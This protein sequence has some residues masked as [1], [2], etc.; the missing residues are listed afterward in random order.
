MLDSDDAIAVVGVAARVPGARDVEEFWLNLVRGRESVT[1]RTDEELRA[2]GVAEELIADPAYVKTASMMP[3]AEYFDAQLFRMTP[4]EA[5]LCDPQIRLFLEMAH[6]AIEN[7]GYDPGTLR[8]GVGVFASAGPAHYAEQH[9]LRHPEIANSALSGIVTLNHGDYVATTTSYKLDLRGPSVTVLTACSS[10][11]VALHLACQSLRIGDCDVAVVGGADIE[12]PYGHGYLWAPG[13]VRSRDGHCRPFDSAA[14][15]TVFG[16]GACAV[17]VKR[18]DDAIEAG[19]QVRAVI[20]GIALNND[21]ADKVSFGAPSKAGQ[22]A[23]IMEAMALAGVRPEDISYVE[24]HGTGTALGD[25]IEVAAL[26]EAYTRLAG[27]PLPPGRCALGSVKGNVGHLGPVAGIAGLVKAVLALEREQL[28][29][30]INFT[31]PNPRLKIEETP[32]R[33]QDALTAWPRDPERPRR[34]GVSSMGI[35]GSNVHVVLEEPPA[36]RFEPH[37]ERRRVIVW[38]GLTADAEQ[39]ARAP[40]AHYFTARGEALFAD[41]VA[42]LQHGRARHPV[43]AA[44]VCTS[45]HDAATVLRE[46]DPRRIHTG[47]TTAAPARP[48]SLLL[49]GQGSQHIRMAHDLYLRVPSFATTLDGWFDLFGDTGRELRACWLGES[50]LDITDTR[51]AQPLL[52]AVEAALG[53]LW[54]STGVRPA[55]LLGHSVGELVAATVAG[56]FTPADG[57]KLVLARAR[58]MH[59]H[60]A[61]G[62]MLAVA[63]AEEQVGDLPADV[64]VAVVNGPDQVVLAGPHD[65]LDRAAA[66]L[67]DRGLRTRRL[68]TSDAFHTPLLGDAANAFAQAFADVT[69]AAPVITVYSAATGRPITAEQAADPSFW[70]GQ[71]VGPVRFGAALDGLLETGTGVLLESGPGQVLTGLARRHPRVRQGAFVAV[72]TLPLAGTDGDD[73]TTM[74]EAAALLWAEGHDIGWEALGQAPLRQRVAVPGYAYRRQ[75]YWIDPPAPQ[76]AP[77][78]PE[79]VVQAPQ[80]EPQAPVTPFST[81]EWRPAPGGPVTGDNRGRTAVVLLPLAKDRALDI[82]L[83]LHQAGL[84]TVR[85]RPGSDYHAH[86]DEFSLR[87]GSAEDVARMFDELAARGVRP[88][89]L[90]HA[91]A[92]ATWEPVSADTLGEQLDRSANTLHALIRHGLRTGASNKL[93]ELLTVATGSADVSGSDP[94]E[95]VKATLHGLVRSLA[96]EVPWLSC[97]LIDIAGNT[98]VEQLRDELNRACDDLVVALR[99]RRRWVPREVPLWVTPGPQPVIRHRGVYVITGGLGGLGLEMMR[100]L[101]ATGTS[102]RIALLG[103][104]VPD[105]GAE[106]AAVADATALGAEVRLLRCDVGDLRQ[107]R[108]ALDVVTAHFGPVNGLLHLAGVAGD[109]MLQVRRPEQMAEVLR[110]KVQGTYAL[111]EALA[112]RPELDFAVLFSSRAAADGLAGSGD[113]AA[114]NAVLDLYARDTGLPAGRVLSIGFPSWADVGM[115]A[116]PPPPPEPT[117]VVRWETTL[118]DAGTWALD[119]HRLDGRPLLPGTACL[120]LMLRAF[121]ERLPADDE[122]LAVVISDVAFSVPLVARAARRVRIDFVADGDTHS[123]ALLSRPA[124]RA[125]A[126]WVRHVTGRI[127]RQAVAAD[128]ADLEALRRDTEPRPLPDTGEPGRLFRLGPRWRGIT[129]LLARG[130]ERLVSVRLPAAF[131]ADLDVHP[132]HPALL[133]CATGSA[134]DETEPFHVPFLY[135]RMVVHG[136]LPAELIA[137]IHRRK[138]ANGLLVADI[139]LF[140]PDG[141]VLVH[142]D[143]FTMRRV[144]G[145][146]LG[147]AEVGADEA[148][149]EADTVAPEAGSRPDGAIG[150]PPAVGVDLVFTL[151]SA[152][153][154][155]RVLVRPFVDGRPVP[156]SEPGGS[157]MSPVAAPAAAAGPVALPP[158]LVR[159]VEPVP[160][161]PAEPAAPPAPV[162]VGKAPMLDRLRVLWTETLGIDDIAV[163]DDFFELGGNSLS[164]VELM[165]RVRDVF[166][167]ELNIGLLFDAP[168]L[169]QLTV[170]LRRQVED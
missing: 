40:L 78:T 33:V 70:A 61:G 102:P 10:T 127:A 144:D 9:L 97:R 153:T 16:S 161:P 140:D 34:A 44:V 50:D 23:V 136:W 46:S 94:L 151:L 60:P 138:V 22:T 137:H 68:E 167:V 146:S 85:A 83:A 1:E 55:A 110:P 25:P 100:G 14:S 133:D 30:S 43:R 104:H 111:A 168:T 51:Q 64:T 67:G 135:R 77:P 26:T 101:A 158:A 15:G 114:A 129:E 90:V 69:P 116:A 11:L 47:R 119:E 105:K 112:G 118:D 141:R 8:D 57:A 41:A 84:R 12:F 5:E 134:R 45:A 128:K 132:L 92:A 38:S 74:L 7:A 58:A 106:P 163:D 79:P 96:K 27:G 157:G 126:G 145:P 109:G 131:E 2:S 165:S 48:V 88:D 130:E 28:P 166:G 56:V 143:G 120:D 160:A 91:S 95:P 20:R 65:A 152:P 63:A 113:Y 35:G 122:S 169:E 6:S 52:F 108:R 103:R 37:D 59:D 124:D 31:A 150:I 21:G 89:L 98:P 125:G 49:P 99:G 148:E 107:V 149:V 53:N 86:G 18:L 17:I 115:A 154:P 73:T 162:A 155:E 4:R 29:P 24:A 76:A 72:P 142:I 81:E 170:L 54:Q 147:D 139:D 121:H 3:E 36:Q 123:W 117:G 13:G 80:A 82:V 159:L 75:R 62:G 66:A 19:D 156:L 71:L 32:F 42:T 39:A 93:P 87:D 164:A